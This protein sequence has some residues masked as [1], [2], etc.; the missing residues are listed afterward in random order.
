MCVEPVRLGVMGKE[1][2]TYRDTSLEGMMVKRMVVKS[3]LRSGQSRAK[4]DLSLV[5]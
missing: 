1:F 5:T 2:L 4:S 3:K